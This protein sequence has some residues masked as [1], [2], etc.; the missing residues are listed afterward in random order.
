MVGGDKEGQCL[1]EPSKPLFSH[2]LA[3]GS[4]RI[5]IESHE[6]SKRFRQPEDERAIENPAH[7][8]DP[9]RRTPT[10]LNKEPVWGYVS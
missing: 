9:A 8:T 6:S 7:Q 2:D 5:P 1:F 10:I 3:K 4:G